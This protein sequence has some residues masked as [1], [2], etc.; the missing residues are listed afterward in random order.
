MK[1]NPYITHMVLVVSAVFC[2]LILSVGT[3]AAE[4]EDGARTFSQKQ[5][6][7]LEQNAVESVRDTLKACLDRI[8]LDASAGQLMLAEQNCRQVEVQRQQGAQLT[9]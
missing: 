1:H 4:S 6:P 7:G 9:F 5:V 2:S 8:P 3:L